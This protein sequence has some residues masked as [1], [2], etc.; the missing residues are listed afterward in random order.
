[1]NE[2]KLWRF[3]TY[4][5]STVTNSLTKYKR[6]CDQLHSYKQVFRTFS[7]ILAFHP[8]CT[9]DV[10]HR[11]R[12]CTAVGYTSCTNSDRHS[13]DHSSHSSLT[14]DTGTC[15]FPH[16]F[17][18]SIPISQ[19]LMFTIFILH[20]HAGY[21][22]ILNN[23]IVLLWVHKEGKMLWFPNHQHFTGQHFQS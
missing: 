19:H 3:S 16:S 23:D 9:K 4:R 14:R 8:K 18:F 22:L 11:F 12:L 5:G 6:R 21:H 2:F 1:M 15:Y 17:H 20:I 10:H 13:F 7:S